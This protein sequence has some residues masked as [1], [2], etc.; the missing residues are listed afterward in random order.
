MIVLNIYSIKRSKILFLLGLTNKSDIQLSWDTYFKIE[1]FIPSI[2]SSSK[3]RV[4]PLKS[5]RKREITRDSR[6]RFR[7]F[8]LLKSV[9]LPVFLRRKTNLDQ[10]NKE[11][12]IILVTSNQQEIKSKK[13][14]ELDSEEEEN[15]QNPV[16]PYGQIVSEKD[17]KKLIKNIPSPP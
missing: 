2:R 1:K 10:E 9:K 6:N 17:M 11:K 5:V 15:N 16:F 8:P 12:P 7:L 14:P 3:K 13:V 4:K